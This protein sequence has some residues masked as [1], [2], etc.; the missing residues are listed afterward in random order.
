MAKRLTLDPPKPG[1]VAS[2]RAL[3]RLVHRNPTTILAWTK[4]DDWPFG[5]APWPTKIVPQIEAWATTLRR[6]RGHK[7]DADDLGSGDSE[8]LERF[9]RIKADLAQLE[10][11]RQRGTHIPLD[12]MEEELQRFA[13]LIRKTGEILQR[14]FGT[15]VAEVFNEGL[16]EAEH[17]L[18]RQRARRHGE[19]VK[20]PQP[21]AVPSGDPAGEP[22]TP[23]NEVKP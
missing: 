20:K 22:T 9:R 8:E 3:A 14:Q 2:L 6:D 17:E 23:A 21:P 12:A 18:E 16:T 13:G 4:R 15:D 11:D 5:P 10:L 19:P 7:G 1:K